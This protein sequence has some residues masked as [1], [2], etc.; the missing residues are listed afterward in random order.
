MM[1]QPY[2]ETAAGLKRVLDRIM[3][4]RF[5]CTDC[6]NGVQPGKPRLAHFACTTCLGTGFTRKVL[7]RA[8][9]QRE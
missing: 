5:R 4:P 6:E 8:S 2:G 9:M 1:R 3:G 7:P